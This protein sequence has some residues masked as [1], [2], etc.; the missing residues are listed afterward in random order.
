MLGPTKRVNVEFEAFEHE[1]PEDSTDALVGS[2]EPPG[3][4][5]TLR[6]HFRV[7]DVYPMNHPV[8]PEDVNVV[9]ASL[10]G[11]FIDL[12]RWDYFVAELGE[13]D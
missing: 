7:P 12:D 13:Y 8:G 1:E 5:E 3:A 9:Q 10:Q 6:R 4:L 2:R 11:H